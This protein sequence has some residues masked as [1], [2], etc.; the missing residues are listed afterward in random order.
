MVNNNNNR[1]DQNAK[2]K[3]Q[4]CPPL[5]IYPQQAIKTLVN[6]NKTMKTGFEKI[7]KK[8]PEPEVFLLFYTLNR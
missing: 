3:L 5:T 4:P 7:K 6:N 2:K 1:K 8:E